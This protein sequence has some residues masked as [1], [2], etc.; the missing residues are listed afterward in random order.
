MKA[1]LI[2]QVPLSAPLSFTEAQEDKDG[3]GDWGSLLAL[4]AG[5]RV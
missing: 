5:V 3:I 1:I 2:F 4:I